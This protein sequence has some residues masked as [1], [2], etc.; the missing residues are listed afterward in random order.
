MSGLKQGDP[1]AG[2]LFAISLNP[3]IVWALG[4]IPSQVA[5]GTQRLFAYAD[6]GTVLAVSLEELLEW[7]L[8]Y[9]VQLLEYV[10]GMALHPR[11]TVVIPL[12][13][14]SIESFTDALR[15]AAPDGHFLCAVADNGGIVKQTRWLGLQLGRESWDPHLYMAQRMSMQSSLLQC[16][17][18]GS[19]ANA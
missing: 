16:S 2:W 14:L 19:A 5:G 6:D 9:A 8:A 15:A 17:K 3:W 11:K 18:L 12:G 7:G 13:R 4:A 10:T 1:L